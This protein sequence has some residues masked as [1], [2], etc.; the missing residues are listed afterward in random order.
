MRD[1]AFDRWRDLL[2]D[3]AER[4]EPDS[5]R[6]WERVEAAMA[7]PPPPVR[8]QR[9]GVRMAGA[10]MATAAAIVAG[11]VFAFHGGDEPSTPAATPPAS[12][13]GPTAAPPATTPDTAAPSAATTRS[14]TAPGT[15]PGTTTGTGPSTEPETGRSTP[16]AAGQGTVTAEAAVDPRSS[17]HW[18][19]N[20]VTLGIRR[21]ITR[22]EVTIRVRRTEKVTPAGAWL[23]FP[24]DDFEATAET[25]GPVLVYRW[26]LRNGR[27]VRPGVYTVAVQYTRGAVHDAHQDTFVVR[28]PDRTISGRF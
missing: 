8:D 2:H 7:G 23:S 10:V 4:R 21:P 1:E 11:F 14:A 22:L 25:S 5:A 15:A 26:R 28:A 6:M 3:E 20:N 16:P 12:L 27:T 9:A 17:A 19:Q 18:A 13:P 24:N